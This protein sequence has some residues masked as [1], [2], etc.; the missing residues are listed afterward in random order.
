MMLNTSGSSLHTELM[1]RVH[2]G[3]ID[4]DLTQMELA[5]RSGV[6]QGNISRILKGE[7]PGTLLAT[8]DKL[9][10]VVERS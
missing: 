7:R 4:R 3:M 9:L 5:R 1:M 2:Y 8:W 6:P 10:E